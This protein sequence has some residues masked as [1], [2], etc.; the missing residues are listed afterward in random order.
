MCAVCQ[1]E[2]NLKVKEAGYDVWT[3]YT[4]KKGLTDSGKFM[5]V[6]KSLEVM[7]GISARIVRDKDYYL[8]YHSSEALVTMPFRTPNNTFPI[9]WVDHASRRAPFYR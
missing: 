8:G 7:I 1:E 2:G 4:R 6:K 9:Y 3:H 5:E